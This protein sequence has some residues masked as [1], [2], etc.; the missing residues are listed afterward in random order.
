M[1]C[2][3]SLAQ[4]SPCRA[5]EKR[6]TGGAYHFVL[7]QVADTLSDPGA[8]EVGGVAEEDGAAGQGLV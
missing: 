3:I 2:S 5:E 7:R 1:S 8:D 6:V 4:R